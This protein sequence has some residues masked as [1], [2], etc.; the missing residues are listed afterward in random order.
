M[1]GVAHLEPA[2]NSV[3]LVLSSLTQLQVWHC[4]PWLTKRAPHPRNHLVCPLTGCLIL[5]CVFPTPSAPSHICFSC[6]SSAPGLGHPG[7]SAGCTWSVYFGPTVFLNLSF[8]F[9]VWTL[10]EPSRIFLGHQTSDGIVSGTLTIA[11]SSV[12]SVSCHK[13]PQVSN[14]VTV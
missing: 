6:D 8:C 9:V 5:L 13:G 12:M 1:M 7:N 4:G 3:E 2:D 14:D 11:L 10:L